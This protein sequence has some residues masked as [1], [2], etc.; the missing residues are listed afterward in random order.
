MCE[1]KFF[2]FKFL[3]TSIGNNPLTYKHETQVSLFK[4]LPVQIL[5]R[6]N[7]MLRVLSETLENKIVTFFKIRKQES[8][9]DTTVTALTVTS[10]VFD[11]S[12]YTRFRVR[13][14]MTL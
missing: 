8:V 14:A 5:V 7:V 4:Y 6:S 9:D 11:C 2:V 1:S 3:S 13:N 12:E 10:S